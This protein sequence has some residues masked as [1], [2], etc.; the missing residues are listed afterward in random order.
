LQARLKRC[1]CQREVI[2][3]LV[4]SGCGAL[5]FNYELLLFVFA[6]A[7]LE[8][9][10]N[11]CSLAD[12]WKVCWSEQETRRI[13]RCLWNISYPAWCSC[14]ISGQYLINLGR[15]VLKV[16]IL[17]TSWVLFLGI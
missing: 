16:G 13:S 9:F 7:N 2:R 12:W 3:L 4:M 1:C 8:R 5:C 15:S 17:W 14:Y 6:Y 10:L 11:R